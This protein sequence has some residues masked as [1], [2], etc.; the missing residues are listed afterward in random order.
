M[1]WEYQTIT[2]PSGGFLGGKL[3]SDEFDAELNRLGRQGW[4]LVSVMDTNQSSGATRFVV[5]VFKR[6]R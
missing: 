2:F 3:E 5:A 1:K 6:P 4:E